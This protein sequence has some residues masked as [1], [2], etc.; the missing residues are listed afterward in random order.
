MKKSIIISAVVST[1]LVATSS[2]YAEVGSAAIPTLKV[3]KLKIIKFDPEA[4]KAKNKAKAS[5][6]SKAQKKKPLI[7]GNITG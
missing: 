1:L 7:D 2:L 4:I 3:R 6:D 5:K